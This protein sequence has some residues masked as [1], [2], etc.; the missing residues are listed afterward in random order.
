[1]L[2]AI[3]EQIALVENLSNATVKSI[4]NSRRQLKNLKYISLMQAYTSVCVCVCV[5]L[6]TVVAP[7]EGAEGVCVLR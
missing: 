3:V 5:C 6:L 7:I 4:R 1:M 2:V